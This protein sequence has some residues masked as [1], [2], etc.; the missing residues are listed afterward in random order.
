MPSWSAAFS[1]RRVAASA[2]RHPNIIDVFDAGVTIAG[3]P[4]ILMEFLE[5]DS[6]QKVL[7]ERGRIPLRTGA[8]DRHAKPGRR[9]RPRTAPADIVQSRSQA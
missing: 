5:G 3:E 6:L 8:G 4:Y 1:T 9:F 7:L 2:I